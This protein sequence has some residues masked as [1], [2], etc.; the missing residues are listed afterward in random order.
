MSL[1]RLYHQCQWK[2]WICSSLS[3]H[4]HWY[5]EGSTQ[6]LTG[7]VKSAVFYALLLFTDTDTDT[8]TDETKRCGT[9]FM[10]RMF[11]CWVNPQ[12]VYLAE[13]TFIIFSVYFLWFIVKSHTAISNDF[14]W[15]SS[16]SFSGHLS[17]YC[18]R[19]NDRYS[20]YGLNDTSKCL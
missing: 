3:V 15:K 12:N 6:T 2:E 19:K 13:S 11:C 20:V 1:W 16:L 5:T 8:D 4:W 17:G 18:S 7:V 9:H 14:E 10:P